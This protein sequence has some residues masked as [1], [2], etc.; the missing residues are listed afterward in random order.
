MMTKSEIQWDELR[1]V[2][3][4]YPV[5]PG[6]TVSHASARELAE[7]GLIVRN[8]KGD[9]IPTAKGLRR[10]TEG[11]QVGDRGAR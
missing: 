8:S 4:N 7:Q 10:Y 3:Q 6:N 11:P 9:W 1:N 2:V 5:W